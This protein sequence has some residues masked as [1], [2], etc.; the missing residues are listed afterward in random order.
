MTAAVAVPVLVCAVT[1]CGTDG[2]GGGG[3][4]GEGRGERAGG[5][6]DGAAGA[7]GSGGAAGGGPVRPQDE[8]RLASALLK[9]GDVRG[10]RAQRNK[11]DALPPEN[12]MSADR[13][14]CAPVA[15]TVDSRPEYARTAY[16]SGTVAEGDLGTGSVLQQVL[17]ASYKAG[18]ARKWLAE[19]KRSVG[20]CE[21][22]TGSV[23][24][25][26]QARLVIEP[27]EDVGVGD[28]SVRFTMKDARGKDSPT[29]FTVVRAGDSTATFMSVGVSGE[30][31]PV[32]EPVVAKQHEKLAAAE[33][34]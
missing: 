2:S 8:R 22:F 1:A 34:S 15:D 27:G 28:D 32:A 31:V 10:Y 23:G 16:V 13:R 3:A 7:G 24:T 14:E 12:T 30:P 25:G 33:R 26:E 19:L 18:D 4:R 20:E 11:Q 17:L 5:S 9:D 21:R 6:P 29:V